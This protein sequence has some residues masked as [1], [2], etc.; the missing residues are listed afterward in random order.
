M[1]RISD[2]ALT[3]F[4]E[5]GSNMLLTGIGAVHVLAA[6]KE[7]TQDSDLVKVIG[8][9][10]N[11]T[12]QGQTLS[13]AMASTGKF[14][15]LAWTTVHAGE[16][17]GQ[18]P[19]SFSTLAEYFRRKSDMRKKMVRALVYPAI[20]FVLL[21]GIMFFMSLNVVPRLK[22]L[23]PADAFDRGLTRWVLGL[24]GFLQDFWFLC[25]VCAIVITVGVFWFFYRRSD[26]WE[27]WICR[28][29][30]LGP[31][32][33]ESIL[34]VYFFNLFVLLK[35]GVN[36]MKAIHDLN[37]AHAC[38]VSRRVFN[39]R[40]YMIGGL[41]FWESVKTD[42]FFSSVTVFTLR[43]GE[44]MARLDDHCFRLAQYFDRRVSA[45]LD[46]LAQLVQPAL[47]AMGGVFLATIAFAFLMPI[48]GGLARIAGG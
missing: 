35:S 44:E 11:D 19:E 48:Y 9:M 8:Q 34:S 4:F 20:I 31:V 25:V 22:N 18:L 13:A 42:P 37:A 30:V 47:L 36:L 29:P 7:T 15:W 28:V 14:P 43:R 17:A 16:Q 38:E 46:V 39:C 12:R 40:E 41:S 10:E 32:I 21:C 24:S 6:L 27:K 26:I 3:G 45:R 5:D 33:K 23:L 2:T 1:R